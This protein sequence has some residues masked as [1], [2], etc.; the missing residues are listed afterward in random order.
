MRESVTSGAAQGTRLARRVAELKA[1]SR[2][3]AEQY[4]EGGWVTVDGEVIDEPQF[5]VENQ[6]VELD[7]QAQATAPEPVTNKR[8]TRALGVALHRPTVLPV[9]LPALRLVLGNQMVDEALL[10]DQASRPARL[11]E[12]HFSFLDPQV[13]PALDRLLSNE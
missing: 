6:K 2:R 9:P 1:C 10:A 7:P 11:L 5:K 4:I 3:E 12:S 8:L 13:E